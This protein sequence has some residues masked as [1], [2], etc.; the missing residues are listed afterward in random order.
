MTGSP[1]PEPERDPEDEEAGADPA[2]QPGRRDERREER[3]QV[4][5]D[6]VRGPEDR[7]HQDPAEEQPGR[8]DG[9]EDTLDGRGDPPAIATPGP[10]EAGAG[11]AG[12]LEDGRGSGNR[13]GPGRHRT[14]PEVAATVTPAPPTSPA[15]RRS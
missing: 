8:A 4:A 5:V 1:T 13:L 12:G 14:C 6:L 11:G 3:R 2:R 15:A 7:R 10:A 9:E